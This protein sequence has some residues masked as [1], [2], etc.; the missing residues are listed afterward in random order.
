MKEKTLLKAFNDYLKK[1]TLGLMA[2]AEHFQ[3]AGGIHLN[4]EYEGEEGSSPIKALEIT[5]DGEPIYRHA[6]G[7]GRD[8][9]EGLMI[10][11][12]E[13]EK[14]ANFGENHQN[15]MVCVCI[16]SSIEDQLEALDILAREENKARLVALVKDKL[17]GS[18]RGGG[19]PDLSGLDAAI[20]ERAGGVPSFVD[21]I[22]KLTEE[23]AKPEEERSEMAKRVKRRAEL[24]REYCAEKGWPSTPFE[25]SP[26]QHEELAAH[27]EQKLREE[28]FNVEEIPNLAD[29]ELESL[30]ACKSLD[31]WDRICKSIQEVRGGECP[32]DCATRVHES[33]LDKEVMK[34]FGL[35]R[36]EATPNA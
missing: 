12:M 22:A 28:G 11:I 6:E 34:R 9:F 29:T 30:K 35:K 27:V 3:G 32:P 15:C 2:L 4:R 24:S 17:S 20:R 8:L 33:G 5:K 1:V 18:V 19:L 14:A 26:E 7:H 16:I 25:L 23:Y 10:N 13:K 31:E 36:E 21:L